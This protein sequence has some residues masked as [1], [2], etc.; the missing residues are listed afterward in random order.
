MIWIAYNGF[1]RPAATAAIVE[2]D[3]EDDARVEAIRVMALQSE[4]RFSGFCKITEIHE[5][6]LPVVVDIEI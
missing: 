6:L 4:A 1:S 2:A 5:L 3:S